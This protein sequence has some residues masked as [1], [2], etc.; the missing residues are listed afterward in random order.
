MALRFVDAVQIG[1]IDDDAGARGEH[2]LGTSA[3]SQAA[4]TWSVPRTLMS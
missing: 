2:E 1:V 3:I 4:S